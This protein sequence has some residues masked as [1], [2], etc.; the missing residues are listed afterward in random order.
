MTPVNFI[1]DNCIIRLCAWPT[2]SM[3]LSNGEEGLAEISVYSHIACSCIL[4]RSDIG[5]SPIN[6]DNNSLI[7]S[8]GRPILLVEA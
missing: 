8:S 3:A 6:E 4:V 5:F 2:V 1:T 7:A